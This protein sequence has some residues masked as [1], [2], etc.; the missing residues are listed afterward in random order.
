MIIALRR[1]LRPTEDG[2]T[3]IELSVA[4]FITLLVLA[5]L[6]GSFIGSLSG[7]ALAKQR[8]A[9]TGLA[10]GVMEQLRATDYGTLS[11]GMTCS[12]LVGDARV[13]LS[14]ACATGVTGTFMPVSPASVN[15]WCCRC[16]AHRLRPSIR[17]FSR[18]L[19]RRSRTCR[20]R[21]PPTSASRR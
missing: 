3:L 17:T 12:D 5:A 4:M 18:Q 2:F 21:S 15:P 16:P 7:V 14:G 20:T 8:Q 11:A 19:P 6:A 9:A 10:T 1:R 13:S